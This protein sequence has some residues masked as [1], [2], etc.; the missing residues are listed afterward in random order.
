MWL[1]PALPM[2]M[3]TCQFYQNVF[4]VWFAYPSVCKKPGVSLFPE[5]RSPEVLWREMGAFINTALALQRSAWLPSVC[6]SGVKT[7]LSMDGACSGAL[8][9]Q[10]LTLHSLALVLPWSCRSGSPLPPAYSSHPQQHHAL[11]ATDLTPRVLP[12]PE[13]FAPTHPLELH[14]ATW[15]PALRSALANRQ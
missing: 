12:P 14:I 2:A 1:A 3:V 8:G 4:S 13:L 7:R 6:V 10:H 15:C 11:L 5:H 9:W